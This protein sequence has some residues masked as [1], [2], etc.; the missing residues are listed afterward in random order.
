MQRDGKLAASRRRFLR[1]IALAS[2][3]AAA[4]LLAA[5]QAAAPAA[6]PTPAAPA[7]TKPA[8]A[9]P[10]NTP[11]P[12]KP[13]EPTKPTEPSAPA[14]KPVAAPAPAG[15]ATK[16]AGPLPT[17]APVATPAAGAKPSG[18]APT[19]LKVGAVVPLTGRYAAGGEQIKNGYELAV[20]E[21]NRAGGVTVKELGAKVPLELRMLD[22]ESDPTK[23][24]Q[25]LETLASE[26]VLAYLGGFGSDLHAAAAAIGDKNK[27]PYLGVAFALH[28]VHQ[29]GL[30]Y[31][32]SPFPKSPDLAKST[33]EMMDSLSP[34]PTKVAMFI[35]K[36]DWGAELRE[37]WNKE[38]QARTYEVVANEEYA[39]GSKDF[40][41]MI[42]KA[43]SAGAEAVL[44]LPN[45]PD[46]MAVAK[47][48]KELALNA[49]FYYFVRA[50][51]GL[52]W[53]QNLGKDGDYFVLA[54]G[55]NP[56]LKFPGV[57]A[58]KERHQAKYGKP[59]EAT[60][61]PAY[62]AVQVLA[63]ALERVAKLDREA[64]RDAIAATDATT[65]IGPVKFNP[66]G[67]GQV[68]TIANQWQ[69]GKQVLVWPKEHAVGTLMAAKPWGER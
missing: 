8:A 22:D 52:S 20:E 34:K 36:T 13:A 51:D 42:L 65:V 66:D 32:F 14:T 3:A 48:M 16:P 38:V 60:T 69:D 61:G 50:A 55:W 25:R 58:L 23:T 29:R 2:G 35:E 4:S 64:L 33:F 41:P 44:S 54:P 15:A 30:K 37:L 12:S 24:V 17:T 7:P 6:S 19:S 27:T 56:A 67:T 49:R 21:I 62:A 10:T 28:Q 45:P 39:P 47:Q 68:V 63:N 9:A 11:A 43:K 26:Q 18:P 5:C 59:A 53:G 46:G 31:L 40:S 1:A 57:D